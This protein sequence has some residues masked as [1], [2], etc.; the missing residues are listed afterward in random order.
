MKLAA[1]FDRAIR[2]SYYAEGICADFVL[3]STVSTDRLLRN[4]R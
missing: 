3:E 4:Y 2:H 1:I